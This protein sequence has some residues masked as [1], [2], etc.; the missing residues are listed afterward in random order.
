M[1]AYYKVDVSLSTNSVTVGM[2]SP[3][4]VIVTLPLVGPAGAQGPQGPAGAGAVE[5]VNGETGVVVLDAS[6]V[7]AAETLHAAQHEIGGSDVLELDSQ[8]ILVDSVFVS[9]AL[10]NLAGIYLRNGSDN[11]KALYENAE[12]RSYFWWDSD[13]SKW[14]LANSNDVNLFQ[15][16]SNTTFPWQGTSWAAISPQT[17]SIDVDQ[18]QLFDVSDQSIGNPSLLRTPKS[19]N[20]TSTELVLGSDTRLTNSRTPSSTLAHAASHATGG[21]DAVAVRDLGGISV[22]IRTAVSYSTD[23]TL[24]AARN[25]RLIVSNTNASGINL[26]LPIGSAGTLEGDT[27]AI[28]GGSTVSGPI[29]IRRTALLSPLVVVEIARITAAAQSFTVRSAGGGTGSWEVV[30]VNTHTH[31]AA[32]ITSG[33]LDNARVNFAAPAAIGNTTPAAGNFTTIRVD[34]LNGGTGEL[35]V[36]STTGG[37][38]DRVTINDSGVT[39]GSNVAGGSGNLR[40]SGISGAKIHQLPDASGTLA[41]TS[42]FAAP[43]AIGNTTPS[44]GAFT[45]LTANT[46][47]TLNGTGAAELINAG[48]AAGPLRIYNT[49]T[50]ATNHERGFLN[51]SSN[52]FQIGTEKGSGSPG[53]TA[54][55]LEFQTDG[56]TRM[57]LSTAGVLTLTTTNTLTVTPN[58]TSIMFGGAACIRLEGV[59]LALATGGTDR[60]GISGGGDV[61]INTSNTFSW[62]QRGNISWSAD[63]V[64]LLRDNASTAFDRLQFGGTTTSF[65]ALKRSSTVLQA[66]LA[67][68]SDFCPLQGQLR[69]HQNAVAETP[70]ATHTMTLFDAAGTAYKVL[71]VAA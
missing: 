69:I 31:V 11:G 26:D 40:A 52:V 10:S 53:G 25:T 60:F 12:Y 42:N 37:Q 3:Q 14:F 16:S 63:G 13:L 20:A 2:P 41:L 55:A 65:P 59:R 47:L 30:G 48:A 50:S 61:S 24:A 33:T 36:G 18:A 17:G 6:D 66:R 43:P 27:Y 34:P 29:I 23:Q 71:C 56:V 64:M 67:N 68:D 32:D 15:S 49:F 38:N 46:S 51:W 45:T 8:Q 54:R 57:G 5:S 1:A 19:G 28:V 9:T 7:G 4:E 70:A 62:L 39:I 35:K 21:T 44:T 58:A 22:E